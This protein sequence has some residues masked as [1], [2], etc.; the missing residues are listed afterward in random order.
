MSSTD[1]TAIL[2]GRGRYAG[3]A[4]RFGFAVLI[5]YLIFEYGRPQDLVAAIGAAHP[6]WI[7]IGLM[8][9]S[10]IGADR[11]GLV[12]SPQATLVMLF[13]ALL[14]VHVPFAT[15]NFLAF[16]VTKSIAL[17]VPFC[18][19]MVLFVNSYERLRSFLNWW[20]FLA[21][22]IAINSILG[23]GIAG[24]AFLGDENEV[25]LLM[26]VMLPFVFCLFVYEK[27]RNAKIVYLAISLLCVAS[28]VITRS[29]G[30]LVGLIAVMAV[31]WLLSPRKVLALVLVAILAVGVYATADQKYWDRMAT[32]QNTDEGTAKG[33]LDSWDAGWRMF[34]DHPLGVGP[35]NF[36]I[37]FPEY[38]LRSEHRNMWGR[39]AH[40]LW[41]TLL[42]E[43][44]VPGAVL[45][46]LLARANFRD[47]RRLMTL[48]QDNDRHELARALAV[49]FLAS[50]VGFFA[51]GTFISVLYFPHFWYLTAMIV[52]TRRVLDPQ[53][54]VSAAAGIEDTDRGRSRRRIG[55]ARRGAP[56]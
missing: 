32:I 40:S 1:A 46:V 12:K 51:S 31:V 16:D 33:R 45:Y 13:L 43:L 29:R 28:I 53:D 9:I 14:A 8:L 44:G 24:S 17:M 50:I 47:L 55:V 35:G 10:W 56:R 19:S 38:Q 4:G 20:T 5:L 27:R 3:T 22:Y 21:F 42:P 54:P 39:A 11:F 52:A 48:P 7:V 34:K 36:P 41:F 23:V 26:N 37:H 25:A 15:N 2:R 30:G 18:I 6:T 49:A